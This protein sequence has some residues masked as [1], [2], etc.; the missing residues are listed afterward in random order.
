MSKFLD[1][2]GLEHF[3]EKLQ[4]EFGQSIQNINT[5]AT[6]VQTIID[7]L[8]NIA[9]I[10]AVP[11]YEDMDVPTLYWGV[12]TDLTNYTLAESITQVVRNHSY[13]NTLVPDSGYDFG[14]AVITMAGVDITEDCF[15]AATGEISIAVVTGNIVI[16]GVAERAAT[17]D[18][19]FNGIGL[20]KQS[21]GYT[22][23]IFRSPDRTLS[24]LIKCKAG[25][26]ITF[27]AN[28]ADSNAGI[29]ALFDENYVYL[30]YYGAEQNPRTVT[31]AND[32]LAK[33]VAL[34]MLTTNFVSS[35]ITNNTTGD[36][37]DGSS[38]PTNKIMDAE[39]FPSNSPLAI[40]I[41]FAIGQKVVEGWN[42]S[43]ATLINNT[44]IKN[45][46]YPTM[47]YTIGVNK[48]GHIADTFLS[49]Y[50]DVSNLGLDGQGKHSLKFY[51]GGY[52]GD[53]CLRL[54]DDANLYANFYSCYA[55]ERTVSLDTKYNKVQLFCKA[56]L[57]QDC[58]IKDGLTDTVLWSGAN[59]NNE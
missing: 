26:S 22:S 49:P 8:A 58:Y 55:N 19:A 6:N 13:E 34:V 39:A 43:D 38:H 46:Y 7:N 32:S 16:S 1:Y 23:L 45:T 36:S 10:G 53:S 14:T 5:I 35:Y 11:T 4:S 54:F 47:Y 18:I 51:G 21:G 48:A 30:T 33:Y 37:F 28:V 31:L 29:L 24:P 42:G 20:A 25:D 57:I 52:T 27:S 41:D 59:Y 17:L 50:I 15:D 3:Y 2:S 9:Y 40:N 56:S 44:S 12:S